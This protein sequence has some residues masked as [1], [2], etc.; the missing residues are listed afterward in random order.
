MATS[1]SDTE[2]TR[3]ELPAAAKWLTDASYVDGLTTYGAPF[4][5]APT[6]DTVTL[7]AD[8]VASRTY[9]RHTNA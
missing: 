8:R 2:V 6:V 5:A 1:W 7:W 3:D 4:S 9:S